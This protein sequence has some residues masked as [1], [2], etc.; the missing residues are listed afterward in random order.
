MLW[1]V[2]SSE[3][4]RLNEPRTDFASGVRELATM[5]ASR[6]MVSYGP[7]SDGRDGHDLDQVLG[8]REARL[9]GR[10]R[11]HVGEI[12]GGGEELRFVAA[13]RRERLVDLLQNLLGLALRV[14]R[15]I[16]GDH[17]GQ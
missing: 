11:R 1:G 7:R 10:A 3:R 8:R 6:M 9:D 15:G 2:K 4:V 14:G 13:D 17:A 16:A 12:D 5:T